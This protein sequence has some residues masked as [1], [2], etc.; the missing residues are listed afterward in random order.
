M[1][2]LKEIDIKGV[3]S[4]RSS[5]KFVLVYNGRE[6]PPKYVISLANKYANGVMLDSS[7]FCGGQ[8]TNR[9]LKKLGFEIIEK[10][11]T[12]AP[13]NIITIEPEK[14]FSSLMEVFKLMESLKGFVWILDKHFDEDGF[15]FL[16]R[17]DPSK[18]MEIKVLMGGSHLT[19]DFKDVYKAFRY[20]MSNL[21]VNV[22]FRVLNTTDEKKI[23]DRYLIS[24][25][26]AYNTPPWNIIN[27]KYG[28]I[29]RIMGK[30]NIISKRKNFQKYWNRATEIS[31]Y[32]LKSAG[33]S[34]LQRRF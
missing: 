33:Y 2:A 18:V 24:E 27:K 1:K 30:E 15:K 5:R 11:G 4:S 6:Y 7:L 9:F 34:K 14:P 13:P 12:S 29:I 23:H 16:R 22:K 10:S 32:S 17:V 21:G 3:P 28:D 31:K 25:D 26:V 20:E 8:E 19:K